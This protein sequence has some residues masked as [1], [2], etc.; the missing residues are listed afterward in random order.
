M[1]D[2]MSRRRQV[3]RMLRLLQAYRRDLH[4]SKAGCIGKLP[5]RTTT[6]LKVLAP[7]VGLGTLVGLVA[8]SSAGAGWAVFALL[9]LSA[10]VVAIA[11]Q[12]LP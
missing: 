7:A 11:Q 1:L 2:N 9:V 10:V 4:V 3:F 6:A 5:W 12:T 8:R